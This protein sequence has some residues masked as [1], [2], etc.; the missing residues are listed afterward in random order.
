MAEKILD[1]AIQFAELVHSGQVRRNGEPLI[2]HSIR[3]K[4]YLEKAGI[5]DEITLAAAIMHAS[6]DYIEEE[7]IR[8]EFGPEITGILKQLHHISKTPIPISDENSTERIANL[9]KLFIQLSKDMRVLLIRLADR[10][11]N[12]KTIDGLSREEQIWAA[13]HTMSIFAPIAKAIG[14]YA[15]TREME[16]AALKAV[17]PDRYK[18]IEKFQENK[19]KKIERELI[20]A[21]HKIANFMDSN[22]IKNY[23]IDFRKKGIYSTHQKTLSKAASGKIKSEDDF[24]GLY[25]L[26]GIRILVEKIEDCYSVL[27]YLQSQ[28]DFIMEEFDDYIKNPKANGYRTLQTAIQLTPQHTCEVQIRTFEMHDF[29]E[30]GPASHFAYKYGSSASAS[31]DSNSSSWIK[32][33]IELKDSIQ[34]DIG[35]DSK[36]KLFEDEIFVFTPKGDLITLPAK[37]TPVDFAYALHSDVGNSCTGC[38]INDKFT[39]LDTPLKSGDVVEILKSNKHKPSSKWLEFVQSKEA[40]QEIR[41]VVG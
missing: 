37:S 22:E 4:E 36:I 10:V 6:T 25:D 35:G 33:L 11:D 41:K 24:G 26:L 32:N 14:I 13:K 7:E 31:A 28:W 29:N 20:M 23:D 15:F 38:K 34:S 17:E 19:M 2:N 16:D 12:I 27:A 39:R 8:Q 5:K 1:K 40:R 18:A 30:Y 21:K 3:V 9:H